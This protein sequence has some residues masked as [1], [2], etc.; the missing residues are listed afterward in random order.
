ML[1][2]LLVVLFRKSERHLGG[3]IWLKEMDHQEQ[4][5]PS[6]SSYLLSTADTIKQ[7]SQAW[8]TIFST[9]IYSSSKLTFRKFLLHLL[10]H[11]VYV[12]AVTSFWRSEYTVLSSQ[13]M[14]FGD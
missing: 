9:T 2:L 12:Y 6:F 11:C 8:A 4:A 7:M 10:I 14:G 3:R 1:G 13:P 5:W